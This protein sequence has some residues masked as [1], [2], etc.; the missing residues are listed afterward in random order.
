MDQSRCLHLGSHL[1]RVLDII[2]I[3]N[4]TVSQQYIITQFPVTLLHLFFLTLNKLHICP[5]AVRN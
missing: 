1:E 2:D 3:R 5:L 4:L